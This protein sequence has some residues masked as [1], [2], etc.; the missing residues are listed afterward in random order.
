MTAAQF[1]QIFEDAAKLYSGW[2]RET[3]RIE[4]ARHAALEFSGSYGTAKELEEEIDKRNERR[5]Q[6][7][8]ELGVTP[9]EMGLKCKGMAA[10]IG[11]LGDAISGL[12]GINMGATVVLERSVDWINLTFTV[13]EDSDD[14]A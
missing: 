3:E 10:G 8:S 14:H 5:G 11:A 7:V 12:D 2:D 9:P 4:D 6:M 13:N 1:K